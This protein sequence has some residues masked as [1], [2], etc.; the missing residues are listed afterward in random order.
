LEERKHFNFF[1]A[2]TTTTTITTTTTT[3]TTVIP[4][5]NWGNGD[6]ANSCSFPGTPFAS[7]RTGSEDCS[8]I[9]STTAGCTHYNWSWKN[10]GTCDMFDGKAV[11]ANAINTK[12]PSMLCGINSA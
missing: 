6:N 1:Q 7:E 8:G 12:N 5:V 4:V 2:Y 11:K 9:C 3:T 10:G